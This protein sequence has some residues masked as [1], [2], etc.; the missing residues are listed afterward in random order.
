MPGSYAPLLIAA[1]LAAVIATAMVVG[2]YLLG[3]RKPSRFKE[4][5]YECGMTPVGSARE[6][7][8]VH[9]Y[10]V[11]MGF[12]VFDVELVFFYP[13]VVMFTQ[14]NRAEKLFLLVEMGVFVLVLGVAYV[15]LLATRALD[16]FRDSGDEPE[17][18]SVVV[19]VARE[20]RRPLRFGNENSGPVRLPGSGVV[21][22]GEKS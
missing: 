4:I 12:I 11:A 3:P 9:F 16:W 8:P 6:R 22:A 18:E 13:W 15:Y 19:K 21:R 10:L 5:T 7:F 14:A 17:E 20:P 1:V 2:S